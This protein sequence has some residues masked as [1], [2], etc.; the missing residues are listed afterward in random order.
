MVPR[1]SRVHTIAVLLALSAQSV[2][3]VEKFGFISNADVVVAGRLKLSSYFLS[4]DGL[5]VNGQIAASEVLYG[6]S[7]SNSE[8]E[9][10][11]VVPC[12]L[13]DAFLG[14]CSYWSVGRH[15]SEMKETVL[16]TEIWALIKGP[17]SSWTS[18]DPRLAFIYH[19]ADRDKVIRILK[20]R[21]ELVP[22][23]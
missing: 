4:V 8:F 9:Y 14:V 1:F 12:S 11:V 18:E 17:G 6:D 22:K 10:H 15:W 2:W 7:P 19:A 5:H 3:P 16:K 20:R 21:R 13:K 23:L